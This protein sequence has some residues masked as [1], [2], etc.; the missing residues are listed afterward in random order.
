[1]LFFCCCL[2]YKNVVQLNLT[3]TDSYK[4]LNKKLIESLIYIN[5]NLKDYDWIVK[6]D[7]DTFIIIENLK[8]FLS[9]KCSNEM[10][11][12]GRQLQ[13]NTK[14]GKIDYLDGGSG[15]CLSR[16]TVQ[17]FGDAMEKNRSFCDGLI[18][19]EDVEIARCLKKLNVIP[20][21]SRDEMGEER[22]HLRN[23]T[24]MW[25]FNESWYHKYSQY[26]L[27]IVSC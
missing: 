11:T 9:Q 15:Y 23:I 26:P 7:D 3:Q 4:S 17:L 1:M 24:N 27:K 6:A 8:W 12:Y 5:K 18:D 22:F 20:G 21:E 2:K 16:R 19:A 10:F 13:V 14:K 25:H